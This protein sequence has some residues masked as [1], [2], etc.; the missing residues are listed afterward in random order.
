MARLATLNGVAHDLAQH[1]QS[2]LSWLYPHLGEA[3][4]EADVLTADVELVSEEPYPARLPE[5]QPLRLAFGALKTTLFAILA[6]HGFDPSDIESARL[7]F[8]FPVGYGDGSLYQVRSVLSS[9]G[10][11]FERTLQMI[12]AG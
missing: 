8:T 2:G 4:R 3:C 12:D 5:R 1:A 6:K 11:S 7:E 9:R 10:R